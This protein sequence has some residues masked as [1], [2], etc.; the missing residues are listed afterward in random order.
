MDSSLGRSMTSQDMKKEMRRQKR[1]LDSS[2]LSIEDSMDK[3]AHT[4]YKDGEL[5]CY[6]GA[7]YTGGY[8]ENRV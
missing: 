1:G 2:K 7:V 3:H 8:K 5:C 6:T 4:A